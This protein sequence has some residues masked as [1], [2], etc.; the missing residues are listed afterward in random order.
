MTM[1]KR[2]RRTALAA[3]F[4]LPVGMAIAAETRAAAPK[5]GGWPKG[6]GK[7]ID[8]A[9]RLD[10]IESKQAITELLYAYARR[11]TGGRGVAAICFLARID[12]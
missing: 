9:E 3:M 1:D 4:A 7:A 12:A 2:D 6:G 8:M 11:M 10:V 5:G